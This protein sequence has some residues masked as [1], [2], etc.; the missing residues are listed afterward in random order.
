[1]KR[2]FKSLLMIMVIGLALIFAGNAVAA[3]TMI[4]SEV[5]EVKIANDKN[6]NE[7]ARLTIS[8]PRVFNGVKYNASVLCMAFGPNVQAAKQLK[9]GDTI[10][11]I[12]S[13]RTYNGSKNYTIQAI[14]TE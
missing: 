8:E 5:Q 3:D 7:Y 9:T 10:K 13:E 1:M 12:V 4:S 2:Y 14:L 6:G 11:A